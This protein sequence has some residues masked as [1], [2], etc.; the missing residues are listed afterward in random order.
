MI[1]TVSE[2]LNTNLVMK[3]LGFRTVRVGLRIMNIAFS[4]L[5][6]IVNL[7]QSDFAME[8]NS[9]VWN[10]HCPVAVFNKYPSVSLQS[11]Q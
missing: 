6:L 8:M 10:S 4:I 11:E 5:S 3:M 9:L 2:S 1:R 7:L